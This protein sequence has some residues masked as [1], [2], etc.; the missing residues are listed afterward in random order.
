MRERPPAPGH[1]RAPG[2]A[3]PGDTEP[4]SEWIAAAVG[5]LILLAS[6]GGLVWTAL[7]DG[8]ERVDP[9]T[10]VASV[11]RRGDR[12]HVQLEVHNQGGA[13]AAALRVVAQL[14]DGERVVEEAQTEFDHL[15][16]HSSRQAGLFFRNDPARLELSLS[17]ES[18]QRP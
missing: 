8:H 2:A 17:V 18:Y 4:V 14:R 13:A 15:A 1:G 5:L 16:G 10:R 7:S 11:E 12:F 9:V 6:M 3:K